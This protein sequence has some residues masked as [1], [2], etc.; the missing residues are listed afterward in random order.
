MVHIGPRVLNEENE[1]MPQDFR[2]VGR[3]D[4]P[5]V[6][7]DGLSSSDLNY[8]DMLNEIDPALSADRQLYNVI[9]TSIGITMTRKIHA[10][11]NQYHDNYFIY[12]YI[13][14]NTSVIDNQG[15]VYQQ[16]LDSLMFFFQ[17]RYAIAREA[18]SYGYY[19]LPQSATWGRNT[20][21]EVIG[22]DS[23]STDPFRAMYSWHGL[24]SGAGFD[25]IGGPNAWGDGRLGAAQ[26]V[27]VVTLHA[28]FSPSNILN[29]PNQPTTT[30]YLG[31]DDAITFGNDQFNAV[32]M[33]AEYAAMTAGHPPL[34]HAEEVGVG[35]ANEWGGP[36]GGYSQTQGFGPYTLAPG[37]SIHIVL[38]EGVSGLNRMQRYSIGDEWLN[39]NAPYTLPDG[40]TTNDADE[41]KNS[42]VYTGEDSILQTFQRAMDNYNS[43]YNIPKPP[44]PP[45]TLEIISEIDQIILAWDDNAESYPNFAGYKIYRAVNRPD[46]AFLEIY[47]GPAGVNQFHD[48]TPNPGMGYYYYIV[49]YDDG[50]T[51]VTK[52]G[53]PL[54]SSL[55]WTR[56]TSPAYI[57]G[58]GTQNRDLELPRAFSLQQN[59]PNPFNPFTTILY[60]LPH[61]SDVQLIIYDMLGREITKL[62]SEAQ[63]A[64]YKSIV[65]NA[66]NV[67]SG[68]YF[69]QIRAGDFVQTRKMVV[70]K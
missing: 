69:Y 57:Q 31:S 24:H 51:N 32:K 42:W 13:F 41:F 56:S 17:Y 9:N 7:V 58:V 53:V 6:L 20:M 46:T 64:G 23:N 36:G 19:W 5:T 67:P 16:T 45:A 4:H 29:D 11:T 47:D 52:P 30:W 54:M 38:A 70:L 22:E 10:F 50:S 8:M 12:D 2:L 21:N 59:Y 48:T 26:Y 33:T 3:F 28:D 27:G 65:W 35:Y 55:Y 61:R 14:N 15:T 39:G 34:S 18:C 68:M 37:D 63:D 1:T 43:G 62:V 25:N 49:S 66:T 44:P 40:S 60:E